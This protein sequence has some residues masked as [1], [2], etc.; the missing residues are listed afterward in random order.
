[1]ATTGSFKVCRECTSNDIPIQANRCKHCG[2]NLKPF[3]N[4]NIG[5][6]LLGIISLLA[7]FAFWPLWIVAL[8]F[9]F[10]GALSN[11]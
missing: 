10:L 11:R 8:I 1:M 2:A 5:W 6:Y 3:H 7:G 4:K 9:I